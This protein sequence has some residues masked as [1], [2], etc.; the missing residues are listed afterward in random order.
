MIKIMSGKPKNITDKQIGN[1][2]IIKYIGGGKWLCQCSCGKY[3][4]PYGYYLRRQ[5]NNI[6]SCGC[7]RRFQRKKPFEW[8]Y[9]SLVRSMK[10]R[11]I[12]VNLTYEDYLEFTKINKCHY[13]EKEITW[14]PHTLFK[15]KY[16][17]NINLDRKDN[18]IGYTKDNCVVCCWQCNELKGHRLSYDEMILL[19]SALIQ[20]R[21]NRELVP[22]THHT[23]TINKLS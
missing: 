11:N 23:P 12:L 20:I 9:N 5:G 2:T 16:N 7:Q 4:T 15:R 10:Y 17:C 14:Y 18:D 21:K 22:D 6:K 19:S 1:L 3:I 8:I 13:C